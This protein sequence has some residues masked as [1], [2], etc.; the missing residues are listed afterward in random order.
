MWLTRRLPGILHATFCSLFLCNRFSLLLKSPGRWRGSDWGSGPHLL[1][2]RGSCRQGNRTWSMHL[3]PGPAGAAA[4]QT[5]RGLKEETQS[6]FSCEWWIVVWERCRNV[7]TQTPGFLDLWE[8]AYV[9]VSLSNEHYDSC[10]PQQCF[11]FSYLQSEKQ[12]DLWRNWQVQSLH[13]WR[14]EPLFLL[15]TDS[16]GEPEHKNVDKW[17]H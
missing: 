6:Y 1:S 16:L 8:E 4:S 10:V 12:L 7:G 14:R 9:T 13:R 15:R 17:K 3:P 2:G 5:L 11:Y